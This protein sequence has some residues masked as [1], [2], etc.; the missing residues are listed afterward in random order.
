MAKRRD[1]REGERARER[2]REREEE[3]ER[4]REREELNEVSMNIII[5]IYLVS[6]SCTSYPHRRYFKMYTRE[7]K[8]IF[9]L[10]KKSGN[11]L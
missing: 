3:R 7:S 2:E 9:N 6:N 11:A 10:I 4:E 8:N 5:S 1:W